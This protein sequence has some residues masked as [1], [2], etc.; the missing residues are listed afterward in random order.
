M[1]MRSSKKGLEVKT[2]SIMAINIIVLVSMR[3][4]KANKTTHPGYMA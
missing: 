2:F 1:Q 4:I 3:K